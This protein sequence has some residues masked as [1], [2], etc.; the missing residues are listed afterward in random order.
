MFAMLDKDGDKNVSL[1]EAKGNL[2]DNFAFVDSNGNGAVD[3][4]ELT[5]ALSL[6][7]NLEASRVGMGTTIAPVLDR[8]EDHPIQ[9]TA[10]KVAKLPRPSY[11][12]I[13]DTQ[14]E[15]MR[16]LS[17]DEDRE[18]LMVNLIKYRTKAKYAD[19]RKTE[20]TGEQANALYAPFEFLAQIGAEVAFVGRVTDQKGKTE[21]RWDQIGIVRYPSRAKFFEMVTSPAFQERAVHKDAGLE[22]SQ[23]L[24]TERE[25]CAPVGC[26]ASLQRRRGYD[27]AVVEVPKNRTVNRSTRAKGQGSDGRL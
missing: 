23:V 8:I 18:F 22:F 1:G 25:P 12:A 19:G 13:N 27:G 10:A 24:L 9:E 11:G 21:P 26:E 15:R 3:L 6:A 20:L 7:A 2:K 16:S 4:A 17:P 14:L 5:R